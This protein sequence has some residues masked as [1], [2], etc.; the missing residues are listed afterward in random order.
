[1]G[2]RIRAPSR[3]ERVL[4]HVYIGFMVHIRRA[5]QSSFFSFSTDLP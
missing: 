1:M 2:T 4:V 5:S 3:D